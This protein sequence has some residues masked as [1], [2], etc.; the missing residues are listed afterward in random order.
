MVYLSL[1]RLNE[2]TFLVRTV[3]RLV[4]FMLLWKKLTRTGS[5]NSIVFIDPLYL[6]V[7]NVPRVPKLSQKL[8]SIVQT[9]LIF[10][11]I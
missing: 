8:A 2:N 10:H 5:S 6:S 9:L 4:A 7:K 1:D 3:L 11:A